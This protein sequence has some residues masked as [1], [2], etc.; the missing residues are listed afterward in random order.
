MSL[1]KINLFG[2]QNTAQAQ[3]ETTKEMVRAW[4]SK[5]RSE[6]RAIERSIRT[7]ER[8]EDKMRKDIQKM[9]KSNPDPQNISILA[10]SLVRSQKSKNRLY[11]TR[12]NMKATENELG[13]IAATVRSTDAIKGSTAVM[14]QIGTLVNVTEISE[15]MKEMSKEMAKAGFIQEIIDEAQEAMDDVDVEEETALE[16]N[17][18]LDELAIDAELKLKIAGPV[19]A[20]Q[21]ANPTAVTANPT[22]TATAESS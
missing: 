4:Q 7:I 15:S 18:V 6:A 21:V 10:K 12:A 19:G 2:S 5:M 22:A 13:N 14:Q 16:V 3:K 17:K 9:A 8:E 20:P 1:F 11:Q